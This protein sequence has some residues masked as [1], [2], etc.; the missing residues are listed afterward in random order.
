V[1]IFH[2]G[3]VERVSTAPQRIKIRESV[4]KLPGFTAIFTFT[5]TGR[6]VGYFD[7]PKMITPVLG[8]TLNCF[9]LNFLFHIAPRFT[10]VVILFYKNALFLYATFIA[11]ELSLIYDAPMAEYAPPEI[12]RLMD[13]FLQEMITVNYGEIMKSG[14]VKLM[15]DKT[16]EVSV[17]RTDLINSSF[18]LL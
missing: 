6:T 16:A 5:D 8:R 12:I 13:V 17:K 10:I 3:Q 9:F 4:E 14:F 2:F 11:Q 7:L 1:Y 18:L 15:K